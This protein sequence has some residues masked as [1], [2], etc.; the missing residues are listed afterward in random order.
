MTWALAGPLI[1]TFTA[2][3]ALAS[4]RPPAGQGCEAQ[5]ARSGPCEWPAAVVVQAVAPRAA[6]GVDERS[7]AI[8]R[9]FRIRL[10]V[11]LDD[12][13]E[14]KLKRYY[15]RKGIF[16]R[17][18]DAADQLEALA[19]L[20]RALCEYPREMIARYLDGVI[21]VARAE[22]SP[23]ER[24]IEFSTERPGG[25]ASL[26]HS[27]TGDAALVPRVR[28][29]RPRTYKGLSHGRVM[30]LSRNYIE[31]TFHHELLHRIE[32]VER[33]EPTFT[34]WERNRELSDAWRDDCFDPHGK[35]SGA[36]D[37]AAAAEFLF[38][39]PPEEVRSLLGTSSTRAQ[40][41]EQIKE[42]YRAAS[43]GRMDETYWSLRLGLAADRWL[44]LR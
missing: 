7:R 24:V 34:A 32:L 39:A 28:V 8:E 27:E 43:R 35:L 3:P 42:V 19:A 6:T 31:A 9:G 40:K 10:L 22:R 37:R 15:R 13:Q 21:L 16:V 41:L 14:E 33:A 29:S 36:E 2:L 25:P 30:V 38:A 18:L 17:A 11:A 23:I 20:E 5:A 1:A 4:P 26:F 44:A 12:E